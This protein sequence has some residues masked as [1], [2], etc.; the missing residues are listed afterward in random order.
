MH[1][2]QTYNLEIIK[3]NLKCACIHD[4]FGILLCICR[5]KINENIL[6]QK[7]DKIIAASVLSFKLIDF[8]LSLR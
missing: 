7:L 1:H 2:A 6:D 3:R 5:C 4:S 8:M